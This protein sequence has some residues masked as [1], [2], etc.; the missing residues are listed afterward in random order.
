MPYSSGRTR[1][2]SR[3]TVNGRGRTTTPTCS[4]RSCGISR[5]EDRRS[6]PCLALLLR[7]HLGVADHLAPLLLFGFQVGRQ[8]FRRA[9]DRLEILA[10]EEA[11][12]EFR[13]GEEPAHLDHWKKAWTDKLQYAAACTRRGDA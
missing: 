13:I 1:G 6:R 4:P 3:R 2:R 5:G 8:L 7:L 12:A 9:G 10:V 11:L